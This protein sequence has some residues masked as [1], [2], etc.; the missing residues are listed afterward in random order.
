M[1]RY[2]YWSLLI[3]I[4]LLLAAKKETYFQDHDSKYNYWFEKAEKTYRIK[5]DSTIFYAEKAELYA[6]NDCDSINAVFLRV[7][8]MHFS[9][10][11]DLAREEC[12][13]V[14]PFLEQRLT[15]EDD[16]CLVDMNSK[17][18]ERIFYIEKNL[19][20][21]L[22]ALDYLEKNKLLVKNYSEYFPSYYF[23]LEMQKANINF[24]LLNYDKTRNILMYML[25][26]ENKKPEKEYTGVY[27][28][29]NL[30]QLYTEQYKKD[31]S[32]IS[33]LDSASFYNRKR[34]E[35]LKTL[36]K[37]T[38]YAKMM[39]SLR[40]GT[41]E[42]YKKKY[43]VAI[44]YFRNADS[45]RIQR[46]FTPEIDPYFF[47]AQCFF[48][49]NQPDSTLYYAHK[50]IDNNYFTGS[51]N[52][53]KIKIYYTLSKQYK[54]LGKDSLAYVYAQKTLSESEVGEKNTLKIAGVNKLSKIN[55]DTL[56]EQNLKD[57]QQNN[58]ILIS[59]G[60]CF[61]FILMWT[62]IFHR[63]KQQQNQARFNVILDELKAKDRIA[64]ALPRKEMTSKPTLDIHTDIVNK[65][66]IGLQKLEKQNYFLNSNCTT[67][68]IAKK[69]KTNTSYL[70]KVI[71]MHHKTNFNTYINTLRI[72]YVLSRL[73][74][75][76]QFRL[77]TIEAIAKEL[78]YKSANTFTKSFKKQT[79][80]LPSYYIKRLNKVE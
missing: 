63:Y 39:Y 36:D 38:H 45:I 22:K 50:S 53:K 16:S 47:M 6:K 77:Y 62:I 65:I 74:K 73:Q 25:A 80:I 66:L 15:Q 26:E 61:I 8:S 31:T 72:N 10:K 21:Y 69:L 76:T 34:H 46:K 24:E 4:I 57:K 52:D 28:Y 20:N 48:E 42:F 75:D 56:K 1:K 18:L 44:D 54:K 49:L 43:N 79:G 78:G 11:Y 17:F 40:E 23:N 35:L 37:D 41:I 60:A 5:N 13:K 71:A 70:S 29:S 19:K 2:I 51:N 33:Y 7:N 3:S 30:L 14:I 32:N 9:E 59:A 55:S 12:L 64:D 67:T 68:N 58:F 27:I